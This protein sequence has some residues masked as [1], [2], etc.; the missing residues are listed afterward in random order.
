MI[1]QPN[2]DLYE[3][4]PDCTEFHDHEGYMPSVAIDVV[5]Y[6]IIVYNAYCQIPDGMTRR[7]QAEKGIKA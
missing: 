7:E 3:T 2:G 6:H 1:C 5:P 4:A